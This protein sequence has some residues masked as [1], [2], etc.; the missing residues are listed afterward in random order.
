MS[1]SDELPDGYFQVHLVDVDEDELLYAHCK[2]ENGDIH[3]TPQHKRGRVRVTILEDG[4]T[5][6]PDGLQTCHKRI[7]QVDLEDDVEED[8]IVIGYIIETLA[9]HVDLGDAGGNG[10]IALRISKGPRPCC[11]TH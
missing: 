3:L 9:F 11:I 1:V 8:D 2:I 7:K 6:S 4:T 5:N 10:V